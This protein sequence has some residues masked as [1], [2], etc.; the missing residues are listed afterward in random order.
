LFTV[1]QNHLGYF[2]DVI[3]GT[4]SRN[5]IVEPQDDGTTFAV[6]YSL[7]RI[8]ERVPNA[9]VV[10]FPPDLSV[11]DPTSFMA[12]VRDAID[13]AQ[14]KPKLILIGIEPASP[15][16]DREWI[17]PDLSA[18]SY[19][20]LNVWPVRRFGHTVSGSEAR[21]LIK[22]G[23]LWNSSVIVGKAW[24]FLFTIRRTKPEVY[25]AFA[26]VKAKIGTQ[27]EAMSMRRLYYENYT[28]S[29]FGRDVLANSVDRLAVIPVAGL[30][31]KGAARTFATTSRLQPPTAYREIAAAAGA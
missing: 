17:E 10:F 21:E 26:G 30:R 4:P 5:I 28:E 13:A 27:G 2:E 25:A 24:R 9:T 20:S 14:H 6:M 8:S 31:N 22:R 16:P 11:P 1:S 18:P 15:D 7:L 12:R 29:D 23:G 19:G 3:R